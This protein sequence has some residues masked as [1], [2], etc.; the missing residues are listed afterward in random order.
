MH[1]HWI[2]FFIANSL[3]INKTLLSQN[4]SHATEDTRRKTVIELNKIVI[5]CNKKGGYRQKWREKLSSG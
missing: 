3:N 4:T 5:V 2:I 1:K